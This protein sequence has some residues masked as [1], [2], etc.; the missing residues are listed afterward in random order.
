MNTSFAAFDLSGGQ[1]QPAVVDRVRGLLIKYGWNTTCFQII[2]PGMHYWF[3]QDGDSV[4]A[5][6]PTRRVLMVAGAPVCAKAAVYSV[7]AEFERAAFDA[8]RGVCYFGAE[9]RLE[10]ALHNSE[11]HSRVL[12]GAQPVWHPAEWENIMQQNASLRAQLNRARN[13]GVEIKE[14][15]LKKQ[16][17]TRS[18]ANVSPIGSH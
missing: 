7:T 6:V 8:G 3:G 2:N 18:F 1:Q 9:A 13:K 5:Y 15:V 11:E 4:V 16:R 17:M 12:L 10:N 14:W